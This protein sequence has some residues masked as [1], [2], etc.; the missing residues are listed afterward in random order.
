MEIA[1]YS[2]EQKALIWDEYLRNINPQ[3]Y[4]VDMSNKLW[5]LREKLINSHKNFN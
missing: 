2:K 1:K 4:K 5:N 3:V